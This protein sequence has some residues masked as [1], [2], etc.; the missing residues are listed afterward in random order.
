MLRLPP[1][2]VTTAVSAMLALSSFAQAAPRTNSEAVASDLTALAK[3]DGI[4]SFGYALIRDEEVVTSTN[5]GDPGRNV[6]Q[7][8][9]LSRIPA[10]IALLQLVDAKKIDLSKP[11][12]SYLKSYK[13]PISPLTKTRQVLVSDLLKNTTGLTGYK[14]AGTPVTMGKPQPAL[15]SLKSLT[16]TSVPGSKVDFAAANMLVLQ[17]LLEDVEGK[18]FSKIAAERVIT[19]LGLK[20]TTYDQFLSPAFAAKFVTGEKP[21]HCYSELAAQGMWS[22]AGDV[23]KML[24]ALMKS[25]RGESKL[26]KQNLAQMLFPTGKNGGI[27]GLNRDPMRD[28]Y[29]IYLGGQTPGYS[30]KIRLM[31]EDGVGAVVLTNADMGWKFIDEAIDYGF[32]SASILKPGESSPSFEPFHVSG[33]YAGESICP[34]CEYMFIPMTFIWSQNDTDDNLIAAA[35]VLQKEVVSIGTTKTKAFIVL[36]NLKDDLEGEKKH[37]ERLAKA[38]GTPNVAFVVI[39]SPTTGTLRSYRIDRS[40]KNVVYLVRKRIVQEVMTNFVCDEAGGVKLSSA[41]QSLAKQAN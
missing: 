37:A 11:V 6:Y 1:N 25:A 28:G 4:K 18:S 30:C 32:R 22:S 34:V 20:D 36:S 23:A 41:V 5:I 39:K 19:P 26:V 3:A 7:V 16:V 2:L 8:G 40:A 13:V 17:V 14:F 15:T 12:N 27:F 21:L 31:P 10:L 9:F 35:K 38:A 24:A 33:E 29:T